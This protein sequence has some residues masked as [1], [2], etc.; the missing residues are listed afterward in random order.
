MKSIKLSEFEIYLLQESLKY[1]KELLS[2]QEFSKNS[3][4]TKEY[5]E[6]MIQ[7]IEIKFTENPVKQKIKRL[8]ATT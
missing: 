8:Y 3:I 6:M 5:V 7:Q 1:Y 2:R 4:M